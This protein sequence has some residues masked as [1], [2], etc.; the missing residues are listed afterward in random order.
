HARRKDIGSAPD[1]FT[2]SGPSPCA[3]RPFEAPRRAR[4]SSG[5][6][7]P[8]QGP[9]GLAPQ[10]PVERR[11]DRRLAGMT[12]RDFRNL[13]RHGFARV[14]ACT[15][16]VTMGDPPAN[17]EAIAEQ[18]RE[19]HEAGVAVAV[20]PELSLTGYAIDD[21]LLQDVLLRDVEEALVD[22]ARATT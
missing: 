22:L 13:Y 2:G 8:P 17:A 6:G 20:F 12:D 4:R 16:P 9:G 5:T 7:R 14:A 3:A 21:L 15:L 18:V 11:R 10:G 19:L 1:A